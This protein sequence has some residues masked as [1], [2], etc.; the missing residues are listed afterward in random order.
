[1]LDEYQIIQNYAVLGGIEMTLKTPL[2][3]TLFPRE[4]E[5]CVSLY[6]DDVIFWKHLGDL[7][8]CFQ[9]LI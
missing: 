7:M 4:I 5:L 9:A 3:S 8:D 2:T 1:M 6:M